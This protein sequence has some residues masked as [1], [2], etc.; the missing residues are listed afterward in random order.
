MNFQTDFQ[1]DRAKLFSRAPK[2]ILL[3]HIA[4]ASILIYLASDVLAMPWLVS[5]GIWEIFLTPTLL[6]RL[7]KQAENI[8]DSQ[9]DLGKWR[10]RLFALFFAVGLSWGLFVFFGLDV[11][12]PAHFSMQMAIVAGAS[13]AASR[14]LS[15]FEHSF[16]LYGIPFVG[17]LAARI[18]MLGG[19]FILLGMLVLIFIAM[20]CGLAHDTSKGLSEY[21]ATKLENLELAVK[22]EAAALEAQRANA[23]KT[24]FLAQANHDLRQPIHAIGLLAECLRDQKLDS[25]GREMLATIRISV[26]NLARLFKTLLNITTID[27]G[28]LTPEI[29]RFPLNEVLAQ[30]VRQARPSAEQNGCTLKFIETSLWVETDMALLSSIIQNLVSNAVK[31]GPGAKILLGA[32]IK[33]NN[34]TIH[35][36]DQGVGVPEDQLESIFEEF[37]RGKSHAFEHTD[38]RSDGLG[39]GLSIVKRT[40]DLLDLKVDFSS[41]FGVGTHVAIGGLVLVDPSNAPV[42]TVE[43]LSSQTA[44]DI[45]VLVIDDNRDVRQSV[46]T[47]LQKW[48]YQT[49]AQAPEEPLPTHFDLLLMDYQLGME[50]DGIAQDGIT[51]AISISDRSDKYIPTAIVTGS[52]NGQ[53]QQEAKQ[54]G[55]RVLQKPVT[56]LQLRSILLA[57]EVSRNDQPVLA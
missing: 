54:A 23:S 3:G 45:T 41:N 20:M 57:L 29:T 21:L 36:L 38:G 32:R 30:S 1:L 37:V 47:L 13:A 9:I 40:A 19:D 5:W 33:G 10:R 52:L 14:S 4:S 15:I 51:M 17:L 55:F 42:K 44:N 12:D 35:A 48:G 22:F 27:A 39:L 8:E 50:V 2:R 31:Y 25:Q 46:A 24:Q 7:G 28:G 11:Q 18:F 53:I 16:Y 49:F 43:S 26:D 34:A 56:P 6:Y